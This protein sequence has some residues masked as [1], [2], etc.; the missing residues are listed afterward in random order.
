MRG[1]FGQ[2]FPF[3]LQQRKLFGRLPGI[4]VQGKQLLGDG[5][6]LP[7]G[8]HGDF[9]QG[10]CI[11]KATR[12]IGLGRGRHEAFELIEIRCPFAQHLLRLVVGL[13]LLVQLLN[14]GIELADLFA[15]LLADR[16]GAETN[17]ANFDAFAAFSVQAGCDHL[18][19]QIG[20]HDFQGALGALDRDNA[21]HQR[22]A[23]IECHAGDPPRRVGG[24]D[25]DGTRQSPRN[26]GK[27]GETQYADRRLD[28]GQHGKTSFEVGGDIL[29]HH[30]MRYNGKKFPKSPVV[31]FGVY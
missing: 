27:Y 1:A 3:P 16:P 8:K 30:W 12:Q 24:H 21:G 17:G 20:H 2:L 4:L 11:E 22:L 7:E 14:G 5:V 13:K 23:A 9:L 25:A 29:P 28:G 26:Q 15:R 31:S 19:R 18:L 10:G 6:A